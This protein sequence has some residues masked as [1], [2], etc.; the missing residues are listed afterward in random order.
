M[1]PEAQ[2]SVLGLPLAKYGL[3]LSIL[4]PTST[5]TYSGSQICAIST[6]I[7]F[8]PCVERLRLC[9]RWSRHAPLIG[10]EKVTEGR[11]HPRKEEPVCRP[12][13]VTLILVCQPR[14]SPSL[15][16]VLVEKKCSIVIANMFFCCVW[17]YF[18]FFLSK[19][20]G[21]QM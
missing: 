1:T 4:R 19:C 17:Y 18:L 11:K 15:N 7:D 8:V 10:K 6:S 2:A 14:P 5:Y 13:H 12:C 9:L 3:P 16:T 21:S 20:P